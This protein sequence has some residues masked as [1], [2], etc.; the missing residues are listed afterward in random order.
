MFAQND[1]WV[2]FLTLCW[3]CF[4]HNYCIPLQH[5]K[6][7]DMTM[8]TRKNSKCIAKKKPNGFKIIFLPYSHFIYTFP[9]ILKLLKKVAI[10]WE[11][12]ST[13]LTV[14]TLNDSFFSLL[15]K[16]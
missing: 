14:S 4:C 5:S 12:L 9:F 11:S 10:S 6:G 13:F 15:V 1:P 3:F 16:K 8:R 7:L 2:Y